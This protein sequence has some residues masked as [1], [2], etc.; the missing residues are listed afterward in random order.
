MNSFINDLSQR[1]DTSIGDKG[2]KLSGGQRQRLTIARAILDNPS[3]LI[4]DEAT[5]ALDSESEKF[6]QDA[7]DHVMQNRTAIVIAHRLSTVVNADKIVVMDHGRI[8]A[9][10]KHD[11]LLD[12]SDLYKK[13]VDMQTFT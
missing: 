1:Y 2:V 8:I 3:I 9:Q 7:L 4:L 11:Q 6:V 10:G 5:S 13:Y 12:S